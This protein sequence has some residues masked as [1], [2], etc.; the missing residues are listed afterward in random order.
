MDCLRDALGIQVQVIC[1]LNQAKT[2]EQKEAQVNTIENRLFSLIKMLKSN[3]TSD[4]NENQK[5]K[6][7]VGNCQTY[8]SL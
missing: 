3:P 1:T 8:F 6:Q 2:R 5:Q 4:T 7:Y